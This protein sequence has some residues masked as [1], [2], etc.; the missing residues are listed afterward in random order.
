MSKANP[1]LKHLYQANKPA[2][3]LLLAMFK[4][5]SWTAVKAFSSNEVFKVLI[6]Y[7]KYR[8][9]V[10]RLLVCKANE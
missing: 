4:M 5:Q 1:K 10:L 9:R 6:R 8:P 7:G 3:F 2:F